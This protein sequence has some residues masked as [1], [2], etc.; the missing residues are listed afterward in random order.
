MLIGSHQLRTDPAGKQEDGPP[1]FLARLGVDSKLGREFF[2]SRLEPGYVGGVAARC[3]VGH[4]L[5]SC[6]VMD[7]VSHSRRDQTGK[8]ACYFRKFRL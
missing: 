8:G 5:S 4:K 2:K 7:P 6:A 1:V 3:V